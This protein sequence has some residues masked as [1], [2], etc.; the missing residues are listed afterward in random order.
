[1]S[2]TVTHRTQR[3]IASGRIEGLEPVPLEDGLL[4]A[5][6]RSRGR[7][8]SPEIP[9][10]V[11]FDDLV[12]SWNARLPKDAVLRMSGRVRVSGAWSPW[13]LLATATDALA[14]PP[15]Q[16]NAFGK[17]DTDTLTLRRKADAFQYRVEL[18]A[19]RRPA[20]LILAAVTVSDAAAPAEPPAFRPGPW[21]RELK[22][23]PRSQFREPAEVQWD[24]CSPTS[25]SMVLE[26]WGVKRPTLKVARS[27][28]DATNGIFG[29]WP[30]NTAAAG[31]AGL[32]AWVGRLD[33]LSEL[34]AEVAAGRPVVVSI[35]YGKGEMTGAPLH[36]TRGHLVA[37]TGFTPEGG[38]V[39]LDPAAP[40][41]A[42]GRRVYD[43]RQFHAAWRVRKRGVAYLVGEPLTRRMTVGAP[44][45]DL[46]RKPKA[47][48]KPGPGDPD[49]LSQLLAGEG[50]TPLRVRGDWV[51]VLADEHP[52]ADGDGWSGYRGWVRGADLYY[53]E[54]SASDAVVASA[55]TTFTAEDG[56]MR[57]S[58][59]S[60]LALLEERSE[61]VLVR[62]PDG[63]SGTVPLGDIRPLPAG[64]RPEAAARSIIIE[65]AGLLLGSV[66]VWGGRA[67][68]G[69]F[70]GVDC[71]G[72]SSLS[73]RVAGVEI[74]RDAA[75]QRQKSAPLE[76][77]RLKPGDL[78]FLTRSARSGKVTHVMMYEGGD[79]LLESRQSAGKALRTT[80][81]ERFGQPL[82]SMSDGALVSDLSDRKPRRRRIFF[83]TFFG[84][85]SSSRAAE[86]A[87]RTSTES[88]SALGPSARPMSPA[89]SARRRRVSAMDASESAAGT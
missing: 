72:L 52:V 33:S 68:V 74:P 55:V 13:F 67:L 81:T 50:V 1:M 34:Q 21:V 79:S 85:S 87:S 36:E 6:P 42:S 15:P 70:P 45:T 66:Y 73:Y 8:V 58:M 53:R 89:A 84:R 22:L 44:A 10:P 57:L 23:R 76:P 32:E 62:R 9:S 61:D 48:R 14:S 43:R 69:P 5:R 4:A 12:A 51:E 40:Y 29:N 88:M 7:F 17:V 75:E 71:S 24:I 63:R 31:A 46:R 41:P 37:V 30:F 18:E 49:R 3:D 20:V 78:I 83:G 11:P 16:E 60:K 59:G 26:F 27:V 28:E 35:G 86:R 25:L 39:V 77:S 56:S 80:F 38:V 47:S 19:G 64:R 54:P 82:A 2:H 65:K